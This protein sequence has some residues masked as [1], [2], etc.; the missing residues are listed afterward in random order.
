VGVGIALTALGYVLEPR[1][2]V[3]VILALS[4]HCQPL[5]TMEEAGRWCR[6]NVPADSKILYDDMVYFDP[7]YFPNAWP[8]FGPIRYDVLE[9]LR[10]NYICLSSS[11]Y[12]A[13]HYAEL[14]KTQHFTRGHEGPFSVLLYQ[15]VLD[16]GGAPEAELLTTVAPTM[17]PCQTSAEYARMLARIVFGRDRFLQGNEIRIYRYRP[18]EE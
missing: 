14:R 4:P 8:N 13:P 5:S 12:M 1:W 6:A 18:A 16:R 15:D 9:I 3:P 17:P 2:P 11:V 10:P 7:Q